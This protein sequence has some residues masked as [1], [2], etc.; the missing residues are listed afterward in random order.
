M[1]IVTLAT[2]GRYAKIVATLGPA[3]SD[4]STIKALFEA[5]ADV[6]RLNFSHGSHSD[7]QA[8][9][10]LIRSIEKEVGRPIAVLLDL[11]GPKLRIGRFAEGPVHVSEGER[12]RF[13]LQDMPGNGMRAS[14]P[15]PEIFAALRPG[16]DLLVDDGK[17]RL[18]VIDC[19]PDFATTEVVVGGVLSDRKG[20]N[21]PS[22]LLPISA[23]TAK[24]RDDLAFG[25]RLG[26]DWVALSFVQRPEDLE[27][28]QALVRGQAGVLAKLEK[29]AAIDALD[30]IVAKADAVMVARGD[31]G[32]ELPAEQVP[33][34]QKRIIRSCRAAGKPVIV[35]TQMLESMISSSVPTR[36]EASDVATAVY[37][38]ADA[39][40]LSAESASG[41]FPREAVAVMDRI[42][43]E[44][45]SDPHYRTALDA[46]HKPAQ[47]SV[48]DAV[49]AS[50]RLAASLLPVAT[51]VTY[52]RSGY[53]SLR[54][55]RERPPV[56][57]I[58][59]TPELSTARRLAVG[60]G[61]HCV[62]APQ[63][64]EDVPEM[65]ARACSLARDQGF[66]EEGDNVLVAAGMPFGTAG[67]TNFL[68][69]AKA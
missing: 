64:I 55:A 17:V 58:C 61:M 4:R 27:E 62:H 19:G 57:V 7:H 32:V 38:G 23:L 8:R 39:V 10:E 43:R 31:L 46:S 16:T 34:I 45:E 5:G 50:M 15:H 22:V 3:S 30:A 54:A 13:H 49:C 53:T 1:S 42:I 44:V 41:K 68:H 6:F 2:R 59:M 37:D 28:V 56:R 35:A 60:W 69:I 25:L 48:A 12:F 21:V 9:Y 18:R 52:T 29:P 65:V 20:V 63:P 51:I 11:Q 26:V 66:A 47:G 24:D 14:L 67:T 36:A 33:P 40:M